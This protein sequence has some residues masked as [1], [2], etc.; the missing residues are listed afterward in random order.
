MMRIVLL[1]ALLS[2][3]FS[4]RIYCPT[5]ESQGNSSVLKDVAN[6][7]K[8]D[9]TTAPCGPG[10]QMCPPGPFGSSAPQFHVRDQSCGENDPNGPV[11]DPVHGVY[12]L[13][14][15]N[16]VGCRGG[17]TYGHAVSRD[18]THWAHMPVSIWNDRSYDEHAIYTGSATVVDGKVVQ[19]Y[20]GLC[21]AKFSDYCP[22]GTNL[23]IAVPADPLDPLQ[24]NWTKDVYTVNPIVNNTGRDPSTA[25]QT[26]AGE[27][28]LTTFDTMIMGSMDFKTWYRIGKQ[29]GFPVGECPS[30][31]PLP[32][33]TPGAGP[34]PAGVKV[35]THVHKASHGGKDWMQVGTYTAGPPRSNGN[36]TALLD[37]VKIDAGNFYA[38]K[39]FYDPVKGRRINW[40]WATV[41]PASTQTL[42]REVTWHPELQ[43]LVYSP[44]EEQA[45]LREGVIG[46]L[47]SKPLTANVSTSL[48][49]PR[50][51]GNQSEIQVSFAL[52][53]SAVRLG[54]NV[55]VD[56]QSKVE[57]SEFFIDFAP[58]DNNGA[59]KVQ[60]GSGGIT[61]MLSLLPT[62]KTINLS[63]YVDQTFT[64]AFWMGGRVAMTIVTK[65]SGGNDDV[66]ISANQPGITVSATAWKVGSIWVTPDV[67]KQTPRRG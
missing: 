27:W 13:H 60:V 22:G 67:V 63:L 62:D 37:E 53:A 17:R 36:W 32:R 29:P 10:N 39:D 20:P 23:A 64:E 24:T 26:P 4:S 2:V 54:V 34:A 65:S 51:T 30:F 61:D 47:Q 25:W 57:G 3:A 66:T 46:T 43:Q 21:Y 11:Y 48:N 52:P 45:S 38:S 56:S 33:N 14:Y 8:P 49:L 5:S 40:G 41:P 55:M 31:F 12:H 15:Q 58:A 6:C 16:H 9:G 18:L 28:R 35:P 42:P 59:A 50:Q 1:C 19:V 7:L 44:V